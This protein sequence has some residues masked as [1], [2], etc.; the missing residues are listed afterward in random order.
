[1]KFSFSEALLQH[2]KAFSEVLNSVLVIKRLINQRGRGCFK[3]VVV[4]SFIAEPRHLTL[5]AG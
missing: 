2:C 3:A 4:F 1:M 5:E